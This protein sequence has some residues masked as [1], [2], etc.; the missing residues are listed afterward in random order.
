MKQVLASAVVAAAATVALSAPSGATPVDTG[1]PSGYD[2]RPLS[3]F[4][5]LD[6]DYHGHEVADLNGNGLV[7][8]REMPAG[9]AHSLEVLLGH[10]LP[11]P[12]AFFFA[13]DDNPA[14]REA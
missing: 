1:C 14:H 2:L 11:V 7:C 9:F 3:Y 4:D 12:T 5:E 10:P 6:E 8:A 13:D